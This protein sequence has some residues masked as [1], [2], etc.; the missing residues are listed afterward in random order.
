MT[1]KELANKIS[2]M[3][4]EQQESDVTVI[5]NEDEYFAAT[6]TFTE[7]VADVLDPDHPVIVNKFRL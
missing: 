5:D 7:D 1:Y 2:Q 3:T 6:L 4:K